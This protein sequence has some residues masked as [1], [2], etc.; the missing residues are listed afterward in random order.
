MNWIIKGDPEEALQSEARE[1]GRSIRQVRGVTVN[2]ASVG[3]EAGDERGGI[4]GQEGI[5]TDPAYPA[6]K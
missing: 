6:E 2:S 3:M 5:T 1:F 4:G